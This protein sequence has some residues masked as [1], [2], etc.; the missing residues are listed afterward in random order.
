MG[1]LKNSALPSPL[2]AAL[3]IDESDA[4]RGIHQV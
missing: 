3:S 2:P 4:R 1:R